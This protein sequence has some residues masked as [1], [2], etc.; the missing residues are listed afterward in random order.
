[1]L[2]KIKDIPKHIKS[3]KILTWDKIPKDPGSI[4]GF[5]TGEEDSTKQNNSV[6]IKTEKFMSTCWSLLK[7]CVESDGYGLAGPQV[8]GVSKKVF[9]IRENAES[10]RF[11]FHP[12]WSPLENTDIEIA[13]E[14]CLSVPQKQMEVPRY[15]QI[16]AKW[17]ELDENGLVV[18]KHEVINGLRARC[19]QH[20]ASHLVWRTILDDS[21]SEI[22]FFK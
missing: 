7:T 9:L 6:S 13:V 18:E 17:Y 1:M 11:Y 19:F 4:V 14:G 22:P 15:T 21:K 20:E 5:P 16:D 2:L 8:L 3:G 10:F 12:T